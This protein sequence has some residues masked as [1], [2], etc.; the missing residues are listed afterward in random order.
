M[1]RN[2]PGFGKKAARRKTMAARG[3]GLGAKA[4]GYVVVLVTCG[5]RSEA[6]RIARAV[7]TKRLA[8]CVNVLD[9]PVSSIYRWK[10][11]V[12]RAREFLLLMKTSGKR[13][14]ALTAEIERLHSYDTPEVIALPIV[15]GSSKY[16]SWL[17]DCL[18]NRS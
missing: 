13:L 10:G 6:G 3:Q 2:F 15:A 14:A 18:K 16:L 17:S 8:A 1:Q 7:V 9:V 4:N 12:E 11:K 5:S